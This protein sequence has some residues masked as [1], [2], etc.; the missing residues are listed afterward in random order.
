[1][2]FRLI[3][4]ST[5]QKRGNFLNFSKVIKIMRLFMTKIRKQN[6]QNLYQKKYLYRFDNFF[7]RTVREL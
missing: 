1:M 6:I 3:G 5:E 2:L 7:P 4:V